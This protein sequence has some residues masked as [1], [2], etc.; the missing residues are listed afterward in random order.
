[1]A[2]LSLK[3]ELIGDYK[4]IYP[5]S[6]AL[7][8]VIATITKTNIC[9]KQKDG[10]VQEDATSKESTLCVKNQPFVCNAQTD[11]TIK[12]VNGLF[13][14]WCFNAGGQYKWG[15]CNA[16]TVKEGSGAVVT[17]SSTS[18]TKGVYGSNY[19]CAVYKS[20]STT[21]ESWL[22]CGKTKPGGANGV[23]DLTSYGGFTCDTSKG[24]LSFALGK[25]IPSVV[26]IDASDLNNDKKVNGADIEWIKN[27]PKDFWE[28]FLKKDISNLNAFIKKMQEKWK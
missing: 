16:D 7:V 3:T 15:E 21:F 1:M 10:F 17:F 4:K 27:H 20:G 18:S 25:V 19:L 12:N 13:D 5:Y 26:V 22:V 24:W 11:G 9:E 28:T 23:W 6:Y 2:K 14:A 8:D